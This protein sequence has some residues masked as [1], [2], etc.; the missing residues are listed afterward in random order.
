MKNVQRKVI[1]QQLDDTLEHIHF[2]AQQDVLHRVRKKQ[3][4]EKFTDIWNKEIEI[5]LLPIGAACMLLFFS[6]YAGTSDKGTENN[7]KVQVEFGGYVYWEETLAKVGKQH[8]G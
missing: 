8:E 4:K 1:K 3:W 5:P 2:T 7:K 6:M